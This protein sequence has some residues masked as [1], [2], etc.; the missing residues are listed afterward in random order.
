MFYGWNILIIEMSTIIWLFVW[1]SSKMCPAATWLQNW[2]SIA[3][4]VQDIL[5]K[6]PRLR[7]THGR[8]VF[9]L[10]A[11]YWFWWY[12]LIYMLLSWK[13]DFALALLCIQVLEVRPMI[14]WNKGKAVEF[15]LE[16]LG[17]IADSKHPTWY[18]F[19]FP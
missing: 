1:P 16:S 9:W 19:V 5:D 7:K 3:Q 2:Q 4:C 14:D 15:L 18:R 13:Y 12:D 6:Y 8:K 17:E 11:R 10:F